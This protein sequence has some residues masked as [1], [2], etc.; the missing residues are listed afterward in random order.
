ML[1][2][3]SENDVDFQET[4]KAIVNASNLKNDVIGFPFICATIEIANEAPFTDKKHELFKKM[5]YKDL[6]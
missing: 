2:Q 3:V 5:I 1:K 4:L 6:L